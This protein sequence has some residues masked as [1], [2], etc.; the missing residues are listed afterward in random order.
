MSHWRLVLSSFLCLFWMGLLSWFLSHQICFCY[1]ERLLSFVCLFCILPQPKKCLSGLRILV[2]SLQYRILSS[3]N[4]ENLTFFF[5]IC[6]PLIFSLVLELWLT[7]QAL[8]WIR[9][10]RLDNLVSFLIL[11]EMISVFSIHYVLY[12]GSVIHSFNYV[13]V[14]SFCL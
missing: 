12:I 9:M 3:E 14:W 4:R 2:E 6:I 5:P 7:F 1:I 11:E 10:V 8:F 13:E